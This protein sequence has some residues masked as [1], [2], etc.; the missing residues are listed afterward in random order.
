MR[1]ILD[2]HSTP[3]QAAQTAAR[4]GVKNL[5]LTHYVPPMAPGQED[6]WRS[7]ATAH[8]DGPVILGP[9]LTS[10]EV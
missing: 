7:K 9:D 5:V 3:E 6:E 10:I 8:F 2:Y 1:D 4:V